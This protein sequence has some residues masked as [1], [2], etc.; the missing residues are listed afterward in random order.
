MLSQYCITC[1][2]EE[3][4]WVTL[5]FS[6]TDQFF[7]RLLYLQERC[8]CRLSYTSRMSFVSPP[9]P[10]HLSGSTIDNLHFA[11]LKQLILFDG[12]ASLHLYT[13]WLLFVLPL[14]S[15]ILN[16]GTC[17]IC[18]TLVCHEVLGVY[19]NSYLVVCSTMEFIKA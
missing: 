16:A 4:N 3:W 13:T 19:V 5:P 10:C 15:C 6:S 18:F 8:E 17:C 1:P 12:T 2:S 9:G 7:M 11:N 14:R